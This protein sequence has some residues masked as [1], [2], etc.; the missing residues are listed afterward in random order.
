MFK[1]RE[2]RDPQL[3]CAETTMSAEAEVEF[4]AS[5]VGESAQVGEPAELEFVAPIAPRA[6]APESM[7]TGEFRRGRWWRALRGAKAAALGFMF[8]ASSLFVF[9]IDAM[10]RPLTGM[11]VFLHAVAYFQLIC[12]ALFLVHLAA[13][14]WYRAI[15]PAPMSNRKFR[16][17][18]G[19]W[20]APLC[21]LLVTFLA[22]LPLD[23]AARKGKLL[24]TP[25]VRATAFMEGLVSRRYAATR[26]ATM[27]DIALGKGDLATARRLHGI[28]LFWAR[29]MKVSE[30]EVGDPVLYEA[31]KRDRRAMAAFALAKYRAPD[32]PYVQ[33]ESMMAA[34][35]LDRHGHK[36]A[37]DVIYQRAL[38]QLP[39]DNPLSVLPYPM[40]ISEDRLNKLMDDET[41]LQF[42]DNRKSVR[43][44][45]VYPGSKTAFGTTLLNLKNRSY[46]LRPEDQ[47]DNYPVVMSAYGM[48]NQFFNVDSN[49]L[50]S[51]FA[52]AE[53]I[54]NSEKFVWNPSIVELGVFVSPE[55]QPVSPG[56]WLSPNVAPPRDAML[57]LPL[58]A[59]RVEQYVLLTKDQAN[60]VD[61]LGR[62]DD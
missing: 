24:P 41:L 6:I 17:I 14:R 22:S 51:N 52:W 37:A 42:G 54:W 45:F 38:A 56:D 33:F 44:F 20:L 29:R 53:P 2:R 59:L 21:W 25:L 9:Y 49:D 34:A 62:R 11:H 3:V 16:V 30:Q 13:P 47:R 46:D 15:P 36:D 27:R 60:Q 1:H 31:L 55:P 39:G 28:A 61:D 8:L 40:P 32:L 23:S 12:L 57:G 26:V 48:S 7:D 4:V 58:S 19:V 43:S 50:R 35:T 18:R 10:F 5:P